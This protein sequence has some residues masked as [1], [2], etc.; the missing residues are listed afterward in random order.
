MREVVYAGHV[1]SNLERKP[2][3]RKLAAIEHWKKPKTMSELRA[4]P[5]VLQLLLGYIM[6]HADY[7]APMTAM[8]K[9]KR[10]E[11]GKGSKKALVWNEESNPAF[12]GIKQG[13][14]SALGLHP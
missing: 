4:Y 3:S 1:L 7:A 8:R 6:F 5:G 9:G 10:E 11:S 14:L 13:L 2:I 12:E